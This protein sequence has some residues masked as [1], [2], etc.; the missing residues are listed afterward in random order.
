M[1]RLNNTS[2][3][4]LSPST[5][6]N[7]RTQHL[8]P[9]WVGDRLTKFLF[10]V[11]LHT[12]QIGYTAVTQLHG[13]SKNFVTSQ[14]P[15]RNIIQ[16]RSMY[17]VLVQN[18]LSCITQPFLHLRNVCPLPFWNAWIEIPSKL[19]IVSSLC[20]QKERKKGRN[21]ERERKKKE[22]RPTYIC[23]HSASF[24]AN[25]NT[26]TQRGVTWRHKSKSNRLIKDSM[27]ASAGQ[28]KNP[29]LPYNARS[30]HQY[31]Y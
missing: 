28:E 4:A 25:L 2:T 20:A 1:G 21:E 22:S 10:S 5:D 11:E 13:H 16:C 15:M 3:M 29:S 7:P 14:M 26:S 9:Q 17:C 12:F 27:H 8:P 18:D 30:V 24:S 23:L 6:R 19:N 31:N